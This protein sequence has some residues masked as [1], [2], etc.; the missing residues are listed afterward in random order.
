MCICIR[1]Y[2]ADPGGSEPVR[3]LYPVLEAVRSLPAAVA[4]AAVAVAGEPGPTA[5]VHLGVTNKST[6]AN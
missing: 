1:D 2:G 4:A 3:Q 5:D 6:T